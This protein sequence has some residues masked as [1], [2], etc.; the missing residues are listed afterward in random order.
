MVR[1][2]G[3]MLVGAAVAAGAGMFLWRR[4]RAHAAP[5]V[6]PETPAAN[7][8]FDFGRPVASTVQ[9]LVTSGWS[10]PRDHGPHRAL[11]IRLRVGTPVLAIDDGVVIRV[12]TIDAGDAGLWVGVRHPSGVVSRY[13]HFSE[14]RV[15]KGQTVRRGDVLGLSGETGNSQAPHLHLVIHVPAS[16]LPLVERAIGVPRPSW[17]PNVDTYG[18]AIPGEPFVPVDDYRA[19]VERDARRAGVPLRRRNRASVLFLAPAELRNGSLVYRP[20]GARGEPYPDWV[21]A[22]KGKSGVYVIRQGGETVYIGE[23][24]AAKLYETL[25]RHFQDWRRWKGFWRGQYAEGHDPGLTYKRSSVEVAVRVLS[26]DRAL[27]EEA[28]LIRRLKPRDNL[29]GQPELEAVPF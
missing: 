8:I 12:Q 23:S 25:T 26:G 6:A 3:P 2:D 15:E 20:V 13:F 10:R 17:G 28:R 27:R 14:T 22:L 7:V 16:M 19:D 11:D 5:E 21:R 18:H 29:I 9:A 1:D 24:H 4:R